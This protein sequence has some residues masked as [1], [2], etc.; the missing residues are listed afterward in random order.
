MQGRVLP[1]WGEKPGK[2]EELIF[3]LVGPGGFSSAIPGLDLYTNSICCPLKLQI[4][5]SYG[6]V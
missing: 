3:R 1:A 6:V 5:C 4:C 2:G